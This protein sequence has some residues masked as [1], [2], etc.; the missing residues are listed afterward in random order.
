MPAPKLH[1]PSRL[2][3][4]LIILNNPSVF[5]SLRLRLLEGVGKADCVKFSTSDIA[6]AL[7]CPYVCVGLFFISI[8]ANV[9]KISIRFKEEHPPQTAEFL[10]ERKLYP[11]CEGL[12]LAA[13]WVLSLPSGQSKR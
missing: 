8:N 10:F 5:L 13:C 3:S 11:S 1:Y 2:T 9:T 4:R 6:A 7:G 12:S